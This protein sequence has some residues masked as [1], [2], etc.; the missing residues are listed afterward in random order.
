ML[1]C[2]MVPWS[3]DLVSHQAVVKQARTLWLSQQ[4]WWLVLAIGMHLI[5]TPDRQ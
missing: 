2:E 3:H 5:S 1:S 4:P